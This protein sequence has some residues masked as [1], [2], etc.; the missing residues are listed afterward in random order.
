MIR[1]NHVK[2]RGA[3]PHPMRVMDLID[4]QK[5][6]VVS[7]EILECDGGSVTVFAFD[8]DQGLS[9]HSVPHEAAVHVLKGEFEISIAGKAVAVK[10]GEMLI[11]PANKPHAVKALQNS[12]MILVMIKN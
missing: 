10:E 5:D 6:A 7:R 1:K 9:E 8:Q 4:V 3:E 11:M 2:K 12:K